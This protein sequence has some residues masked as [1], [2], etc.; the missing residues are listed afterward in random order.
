MY[1]IWTELVTLYEA[2]LFQNFIWFSDDLI[3]SNNVVLYLGAALYQ[4]IKGK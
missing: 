1:R 4:V 3:V 2:N